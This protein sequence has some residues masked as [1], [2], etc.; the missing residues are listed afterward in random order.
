MGKGKVM[1]EMI[2]FMNAPKIEHLIPH[3]IDVIAPFH[4]QILGEEYSSPL[5]LLSL[6]PSRTITLSGCF[7][8]LT[9]YRGSNLDTSLRRRTILEL[10]LTNMKVLSSLNITF[11]HCSDVQSLCYLQ[12][13]SLCFLWPRW[14]G[15]SWRHVEL[16]IW[17]RSLG[18][19][20]SFSQQRFEGEQDVFASDWQ[21][22][23]ICLISLLLLRSFQCE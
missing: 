1:H 11:W 15:S 13:S 18:D 14:E 8:V 22:L 16:A 2:T 21:L 19:F 12:K 23:N 9:M 17:G 6:K 20:G 5:P 3:N 4:S 10:T 7:I